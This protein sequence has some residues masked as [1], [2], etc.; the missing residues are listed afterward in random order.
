V[1]ALRT[2]NPPPGADP[3][4]LDPVTR[5]LVVTR[6]AV[7]PMTLIAAL[8]AGLLAV[9]ADGFSGP[10]LLLAVAGLLAAHACNNLLNDLSDTDVGLDTAGY[11]RAQY[12]PHPILSGMVRRRSVG[13]AVL[14]LM[15]VD[16]A[17]LV[18]LAC[19]GVA[20]RRL[21]ARRA[22]A[23]DRVRHPAPAAQGPG[24]G[25]LEVLLVWGPL[26]IAGTYYSAVG[27]LPWQVWSRASR[28]A[29]CAPAS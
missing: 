14:G 24:L 28:T 27:E 15:A 19:N 6:A 8:V 5:W 17:V 29:C 26:M 25:E 21:R 4:S 13:L 1:Y 10:L 23:L 16:L 20:G 11:P 18:A 3:G 22:G 12:A 9:R 7:L 2:T